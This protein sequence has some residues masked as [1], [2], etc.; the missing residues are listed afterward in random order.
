MKIIRKGQNRVSGNRWTRK[1]GDRIEYPYYLSNELNELKIM[2]REIVKTTKSYDAGF[3]LGI[4]RESKYI[5]SMQEKFKEDLKKNIMDELRNSY[6][7]LTDPFFVKVI[8]PSIDVENLAI[9]YMR[10]QPS[11]MERW[12]SR[13]QRDWNSSLFKYICL[14]SYR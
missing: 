6:P 9:P 7:P 10:P 8:E 14:P 12:Y 11:I 13:Y 4:I 2:I 5:A 1:P 3:I